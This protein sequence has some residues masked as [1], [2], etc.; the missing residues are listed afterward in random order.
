MGKVILTGKGRRWIQS[1]HPWIYRD[2]LKD[3]AAENGDVVAVEDTHGALVGWGTYSAVSRIAVRMVT[4]AR[5]EPDREFWRGRIAR[6]LKARTALGL[7]AAD[8][9][10]KSCT[11]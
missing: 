10:S 5:R 3:A 8:G 7:S 1:G 11:A 6:A 2:D 9:A 4:R